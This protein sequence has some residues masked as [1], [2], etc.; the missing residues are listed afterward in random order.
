[1]MQVLRTN[2]IGVSE[3]VENLNQEKCALRK[4]K[5]LLCDTD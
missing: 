3:L 5:G 4:I 1:M 2:Y